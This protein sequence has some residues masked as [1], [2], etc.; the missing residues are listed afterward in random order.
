MS[1]KTAVQTM[2]TA[3]SPRPMTERTRFTT[4]ELQDDACDG[5]QQQEEEEGEGKGAG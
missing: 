5:Q 4:A 1:A 2:E 3:R